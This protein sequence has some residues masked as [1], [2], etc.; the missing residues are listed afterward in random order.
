MTRLVDEAPY[1]PYLAQ[2]D[3]WPSESKEGEVSIHEMVPGYA[4][5]AYRRLCD[6]GLEV[7]ASNVKHTALASALLLRA[8]GE[9]VT[10]SADIPEVPITQRVS[11][12][13]AFDWLA[14]LDDLGPPTETHPITRARM[15]L[16]L[17]ADYGIETDNA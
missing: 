9:P 13:A 5:N 12:E 1:G 11:L 14:T 8:V 6:W 3:R 2:V 7:G 17:M 10:Y 15:L 16:K 4:I